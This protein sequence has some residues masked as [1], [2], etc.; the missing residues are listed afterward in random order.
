MGIHESSR[1]PEFASTFFC[2]MSAQWMP[3]NGIEGPEPAEQ[4]A[5]NP[6]GVGAGVGR[7]S[8]AVSARDRGPYTRRAGGNIE[9]NRGSARHRRADCELASRARFREAWRGKP[10]GGG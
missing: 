5:V 2:L 6:S 7:E 1:I 3:V 10:R 8:V 9:G 4:Q